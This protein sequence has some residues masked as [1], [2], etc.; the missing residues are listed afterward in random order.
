MKND[1]LRAQYILKTEYNIDALEEG[2]REKDPE[3]MEWVFETR[4]EIDDAE[5]GMELSAI[6]T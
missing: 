5:V 3:V 6:Q 1:I 2:E 4:M